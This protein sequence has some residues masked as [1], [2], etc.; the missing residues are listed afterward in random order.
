MPGLGRPLLTEYVNFPVTLAPM[1][2]LSHVGL[3]SVVRRYLPKG[4]NTFWP[5]EMLNSRRIPHENLGGTP[6]TYRLDEEMDLVPQILGNEHRPIKETL[7]KM[8]EWGVLG[9]DINMGC[10]V[11]KALKHNYGVALMGDKQYAA[12]VV[13]MARE[14]THLPLSVKLRAVDPIEIE[15][16][17]E[18]VKPLV[19]AGADWICLHPRTAAQKRR[20]KANWSQIRQLRE[21]ISVPIIGNGDVQCLEDLNEIFKSTHCDMVMVGRGLAARPWLLWQ[22]AEQFGWEPPPERSGK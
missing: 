21:S 5:T 13:G 4:A 2:G 11:K 9:V 17:V 15:P 20:G 12:D 6:E 8:H 22:W 7:Q 14:A 1:V 3:R 19:D 16:L 18:F 10:P